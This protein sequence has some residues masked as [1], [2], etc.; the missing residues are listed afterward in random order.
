MSRTTVSIVGKPNVGKST[1]FNRLVGGR[2]AI[3]EDFEGV[4]RD[5]IY[6]S[7][8]WLQKSFSLI[9][10]GGFMPDTDD[11]MLSSMQL[12]TQFAIEEADVILCLFDGQAEL[13]MTD[14]EIVT[15]LRQSKKPVYYVAN[16]IDGPEHEAKIFDLYHL[17]IANII[18]ISAE[19]KRG[20]DELLDRVCEH[21]Q[22]IKDDEQ[23][24]AVMRIAVVGRPNAGKSSLINQLLGQERML[25][26]DIAGTT[27]DAIDSDFSFNG[28]HY[29]FIDTA[30]IRRKSKITDPV[31]RYSVVRAFKSI[32]RSHIAFV[33]L[34]ATQG[35]TDQDA[36]IAGYAHNNGR[37][38][39][40]LVNKWD[41]IEKDT[42]TAGNF[43]IDIKY[44]L[45][46]LDYAPII[47]VS[48]LT[49]QRV[50][51]TL[52][53]A[54]SMFAQYNKRVSTSKINTALQ[55]IVQQHHPP[56]YKGHQVKFYYG[57]QNAVRPPT[58][59]LFCNYPDG[60][61]FSYRR[62]LT[63]QFRE[64]FGFHE[65]PLHLRIQAR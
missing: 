39:L 53:L 9:D 4:T 8:T 44:K 15:R 7:C 40:L 57:T 20:L 36:R 13:T 12:Q 55:E 16:K 14:Y 65:I 10:T 61:H 42:S 59:T 64:Y 56:V 18:P 25:V 30:G 6:G 34:D 11:P 2:S 49:G 17:G 29:T 5:R 26:T 46:Y 27:R 28:S 33:M 54:D 19:H 31:E 47:F 43:A 32:D 21:V 51:K 45:K 58:L 3:T 24:N 48:A 62:Y 1:L 41:L 52:A 38:V 63:N 22:V 50:L 35:V 23:D 60:V 37:A